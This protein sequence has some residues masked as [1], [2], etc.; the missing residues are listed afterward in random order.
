LI[1]FFY[2][3]LP[4]CNAVADFLSVAAT[5]GFLGYVSAK[6]PGLLAILTL[7][8][9]DLV[10]GATFLGLLLFLLTQ[11]LDLWAFWLPDTQPLDWRAYWQTAQID[12]W[13]G[14]A[15]WLMALTTLLPTLFHLVSGIGAVLTH[16][17]RLQSGAIRRLQECIASGGPSD[18]DC[19]DIAK[20]LIRGKFYGHTMAA[21]LLFGFGYLVWRA[22]PTIATYAQQFLPM[23]T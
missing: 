18:P 11:L 1:L 5:R 8:C 2:L 10:L 13:Q 21:T 16:S 12:P 19:T 17:L 9:F 3:L 6:R 15:L 4:L 14:I 22:W 23:T 20:R 7:L